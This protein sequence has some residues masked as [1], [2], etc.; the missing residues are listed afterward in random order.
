MPSPWQSLA[1]I[2]Y[3]L[4]VSIWLSPICL[5]RQ[6]QVQLSYCEVIFLLKE[7]VINVGINGS[8]HIHVNYWEAITS[9]RKEGGARTN[10]W[11]G[12]AI[13]SRSFYCQYYMIHKEITAS[14]R[15]GNMFI[16]LC[17]IQ[18]IWAIYGQ[19]LVIITAVMIQTHFR[20][21]LFAFMTR[22]ILIYLV[23]YHVLHLL[24]HF[25]FSTN[26]S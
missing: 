3:W 25:C 21:V 11:K 14:E 23:H 22:L 18:Y 5:L 24:L 19:L 13:G 12:Q 7:A 4:N 16:L 15:V 17:V 1:S 26:M 2:N 6:A 10:P 9:K 20:W 8:K